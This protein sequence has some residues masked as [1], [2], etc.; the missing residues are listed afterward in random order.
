MYRYI[1]EHP[2]WERKQ[3]RKEQET[4]IRQ[5]VLLSTNRERRENIRDNYKEFFISQALQQYAASDDN[6]GLDQQEVLSRLIEEW[7]KSSSMQHDGSSIHK[8]MSSSDFTLFS[9]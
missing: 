9:K 4:E 3:I 5:T 1:Y 7:Y 6:L 2:Y 8:I